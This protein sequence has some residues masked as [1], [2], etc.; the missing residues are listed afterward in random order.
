VTLKA[1]LCGIGAQTL[2]KSEFDKYLVAVSG[3]RSTYVIFF[4]K[5]DHDC[6]RQ[7]IG[8]CDGNLKGPDPSDDRND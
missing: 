6:H 4:I 3:G 5:A 1:N 2:V 8:K 7:P